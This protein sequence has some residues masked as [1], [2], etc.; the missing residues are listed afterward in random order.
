MESLWTQC[1]NLEIW[2]KNGERLRTY[3]DSSKTHLDIL[4]GKLQIFQI[5]IELECAGYSDLAFV[6]VFCSLGFDKEQ[7]RK[8]DE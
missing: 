4:S 3:P 6:S 8:Y 2:L 1:K 5:K 7:E